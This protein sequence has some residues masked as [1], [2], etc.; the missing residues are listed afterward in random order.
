ML[1][2]ETRCGIP[3]SPLPI[4]SLTFTCLHLISIQNGLT[5][6]EVARAKQAERSYYSYGCDYQGVI[7]LLRGY[8][9]EPATLPSHDV[10]RLTATAILN[11]VITGTISERCVLMFPAV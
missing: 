9:E 2:S 3:P 1:S 5:P 8:S 7:D 11:D 6:L 10:S 4:L